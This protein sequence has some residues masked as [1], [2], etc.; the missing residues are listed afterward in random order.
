MT[1]SLCR[2]R[3]LLSDAREEE[4]LAGGEND[5]LADRKE[6]SVFLVLK[7]LFTRCIH[8]SYRR[9]ERAYW[10]ERSPLRL[11]AMRVDGVGMSIEW[12]RRRG[13]AILASSDPRSERVSEPRQGRAHREARSADLGSARG[14]NPAGR[15]ALGSHADRGILRHSRAK[16]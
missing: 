6:G 11:P 2:D 1:F 4:A 5:H 14:G 9:K 12:D 10:Y 16:T 7:A 8:A 13:I 15:S 3:F